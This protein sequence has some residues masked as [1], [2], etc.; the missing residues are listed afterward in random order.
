M[1]AGMLLYVDGSTSLSQRQYLSIPFIKSRE[2][3]KRLI[4]HSA[5]GYF[6]IISLLSSGDSIRYPPSVG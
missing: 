1:I 5:I 4:R 2:P 6:W 3:T